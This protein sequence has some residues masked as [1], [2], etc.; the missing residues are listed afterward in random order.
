MKDV[1]DRVWH[2][3]GDGAFVAGILAYTFLACL[4]LVFSLPPS[5]EP[6]ANVPQTAFVPRACGHCEAEG[7]RQTRPHDNLESYTVEFHSLGH[8]C[9]LSVVQHANRS[10]YH[11]CGTLANTDRSS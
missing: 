1:K 3:A 9:A 2:P 4:C 7:P 8:G 11:W 10:E 6:H 5:G